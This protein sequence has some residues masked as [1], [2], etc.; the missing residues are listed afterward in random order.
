MFHKFMLGKLSY[1]FLL[2]SVVHIAQSAELKPTNA[3]TQVMGRSFQQ[4]GEIH[5]SWAGVVFSSRFY[6]SSIG[7]QF[8]DDVNHYNV[9]IDGKLVKVLKTPGDTIH[10]IS[11]LSLENHHIRLVKRTESH[12]SK[13]SFLGFA[14]EKDG[15]LLK[16]PKARTRQIEFKGDSFTAGYGNESITRTCDE[17]TR[18]ERSNATSTYAALSAKH[19]DADYHLNAYSGAGMVRNYNGNSPEQ[20]YLTFA[21][22]IETYEKNSHWQPDELW[23]PQLIVIFLGINDFSEPVREEETWTPSSLAK[24]YRVNYQNHISEM[25]K[26]HSNAQFLLLSIKTGEKPALLPS[27][28]QQVGKHFSSQQKANVHTLEL[29]SNVALNGCHWHPSKEDNLAISKQ[30]ISKIESMNINW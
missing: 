3:F 2:L 26:K 6:G 21:N 19:F 22:R 20:S 17:S 27:L 24:N 15:Q 29:T 25:M 4:N 14:T 18:F 30:V 12:N 5:Y 11:D 8:Q 1:I 23:S 16:I 7:F 13:S 28:V 10:W 9:E